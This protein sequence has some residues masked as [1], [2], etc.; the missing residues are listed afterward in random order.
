[1]KKLTIVTQTNR[2][3]GRVVSLALFSTLVLSGCGESGLEPIRQEALNDASI[4]V[5]LMVGVNR[6]T[7]QQNRRQ[8]LPLKRLQRF[9]TRLLR[10]H[11]RLLISVHLIWS[12]VMNFKE[13]PW[14][15]ASGILLCSGDRMSRSITKCNIM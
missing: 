6:R 15:R 7:H 14:I 2:M 10:L 8:K 9:P 1:M 13:R 11:Q 3:S 12:L 5:R 4:L